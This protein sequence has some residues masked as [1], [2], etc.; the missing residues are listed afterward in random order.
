MTDASH[1]DASPSETPDAE[2]R[3]LLLRLLDA[4]VTA[5][6]PRGCLVP[7]LPPVPAGRLVILGAGKA[8]ASMAALAE[9]HY[10]AHGVD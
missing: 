8:G 5:A 6:H 10:R 1:R 3:A 9:R 2:T 7:H 4:G